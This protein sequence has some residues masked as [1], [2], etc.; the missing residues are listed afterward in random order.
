MVIECEQGLEPTHRQKVVLRLEPLERR[1]NVD[2]GMLVARVGSATSTPHSTFDDR[3][4]ARIELI[5]AHLASQD[6][7]MR[8]DVSLQ[9]DKLAA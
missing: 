5:T 2:L 8:L 3:A 7:S 6:G 9:V 1:F 4:I